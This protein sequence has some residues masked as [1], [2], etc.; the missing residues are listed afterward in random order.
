MELE[1][2]MA[3]L[4]V[5]TLLD[6]QPNGPMLQTLNAYLVCEVTLSKRRLGHLAGVENGYA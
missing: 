5:N 6:L 3:G 1:N 4:K 2:Q